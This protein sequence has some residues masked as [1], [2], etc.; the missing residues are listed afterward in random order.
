ME[1]DYYN[2]IIVIIVQCSVGYWWVGLG[3][4]SVDTWFIDSC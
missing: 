2:T 1:L 4:E 3:A